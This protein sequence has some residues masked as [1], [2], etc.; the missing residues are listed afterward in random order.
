MLGSGQTERCETGEEQS[1]EHALGRQKN[2][3][4]HHENTPSY[5]SFFTREFF[6]KNNMTVIPNPPC[7]SVSPIEDKTEIRHFDTIEVIEAESQVMLN[8]LTEH[9]M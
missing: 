3:L 4:L 1:Q 2:W 6:T 9:D 5:T 8:T 7:L